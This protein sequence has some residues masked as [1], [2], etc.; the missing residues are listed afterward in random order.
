MNR[1]LLC[2]ALALLPAC[3]A[4]APDAP[5]GAE[6][7]TRFLMSSFYADDA[8][9]GAG[10]TGLMNWYDDEGSAIEGDT[11]GIEEGEA[12]DW[13][14]APLTADDLAPTQVSTTD[15]PLDSMPGFIGVGTVLC[16]FEEAEALGGRAD[17][18]VVYDGEWAHYAR[19]FESARADYDAATAGTIPGLPD[20]VDPLVDD[21]S[22][23]AHSLMTTSNALGTLEV[24]VAL[25][26]TLNLH[27][28]HGVFDIQG[29]ERRATLI[30]TWQPDPTTGEGGNNSLH[31]T[32]AIDALVEVDG[33]VRRFAA[34]WN[35]VESAVSAPT[36]VARLT[37]NRIND[38]AERM[39]EICTGA[40]ELPAE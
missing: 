36:V 12:Q 26:Y 9:I 3:Q 40:A 33:G 8:T 24:G 29:E 23:T 20:G 39:T 17:Q 7:G 14:L 22:A 1:L 35:D 30:L 21:L 16:T 4:P 19:T 37:I 34:T 13:T 28:R 18:D 15:R 10:L 25:D 2:G 5:E 6:E 11:P 38:F 27:F 31:Q 32:F